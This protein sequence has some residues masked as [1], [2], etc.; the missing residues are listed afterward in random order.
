MIQTPTKTPHMQFVLVSACLLGSPVRYDG[1]HNLCKNEVLQH[2][3]DEGRVIS[4]CPEV[5]GGLPTP[6]PPAKFID[7]ARLTLETAK[8]MGI[9]LAALKEGSPSCGST[10][11]HDGSFTGTMVPQMGVTAT[12]LERSGIR[13]FS[14]EHLVEANAYLLE[15]EACTNP[16]SR[17]DLCCVD[18]PTSES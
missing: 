1:A 3:R 8:R 2:W 13:V 16:H 14:E 15:L 4:I 17:H 6:R 9:R 10:Y 5:V 18:I 7:G 12:L 11:I